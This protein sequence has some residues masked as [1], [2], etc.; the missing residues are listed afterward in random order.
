MMNVEIFHY[1]VIS[2]VF[3]RRRFQ[4]SETQI[5]QS[6]ERQDIRLVIHVMQMQIVILV[7]TNLN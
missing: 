5:L 1:D 6:E 4:Q 3:I 2:E 7:Q